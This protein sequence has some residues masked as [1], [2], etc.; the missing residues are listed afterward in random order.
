[1]LFNLAQPTPQPSADLSVIF[2]TLEKI[3]LSYQTVRCMDFLSSY[4]SLGLNYL[5]ANI[6]LS[7][8]DAE[9]YPHFLNDLHT[10][11]HTGILQR[12][13][14][15]IAETIALRKE[16]KLLSSA[17][18]TLFSIQD[19]YHYLPSVTGGFK[20]TEDRMWCYSKMI[21]IEQALFNKQ[22]ITGGHIHITDLLRNGNKTIIMSNKSLSV[23]IDYKNGGQVFEIDYKDRNYNLC[24]ALGPSRHAVPMI[25]ESPSSKTAFIDHCLSSETGIEQFSRNHF[26]ECGDFVGEDFNYK[27]KKTA[28]GIRT[29]LRR[30][31][32]LLQGEKN[33]PLTVE[34]VLGLEKDAPVLLFVY[35][36]ANT[37]LTSYAFRFAIENTFS[38]PGIASG[39]ARILHGKTVH[40][41]LDTTPLTLNQITEW[42]IDDALCGIRVRFVMQK[43]V[44]V[45]C[46]PVPTID[47]HADAHAIAIVISAPV[48]LEGTKAWSLMGT[49]EIKK[50]RAEKE[51]TDEI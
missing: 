16:A 27:I 36:L 14:M 25:V 28:S 12:K 48:S 5:P 33:C 3:M 30:N 47:L 45:W 11:D 29:V 2:Q 17:I 8:D 42:T 37:S 6:V 41:D 35:Q 13:L 24:A 49:M 4:F 39:R 20:Q 44:D 51:I 40:K 18:K 23:G 15:N 38:F 19:A 32:S 34:K 9:S 10:Y 46:T 1:M 26:I 21:E 50:V 31:G 7:R 22:E 43:P